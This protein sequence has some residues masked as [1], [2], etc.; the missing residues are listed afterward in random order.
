ME[1]TVL[2][3]GEMGQRALRC[4]EDPPSVCHEELGELNSSGL[5]Q[6]HLSEGT[7]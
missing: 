3:S 1:E 6:C 7:D 2:L 4:L 5:E